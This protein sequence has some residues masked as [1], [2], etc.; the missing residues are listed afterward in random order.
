MSSQYRASSLRRASVFFVPPDALREAS[1]YS[2]SEF[3]LRT[4]HDLKS[5][6][7]AIRTSAELMQ[8]D[9]AAAESA[10]RHLGTILTGA[11]NIDVLADGLIAYSLATQIEPSSFRFAGSGALLRAA[12]ARL[13][14]EL[15]AQNAEVTYGDLPRVFGDPDRLTEVFDALLKNAVRY[16]SAAPPRIRVTAEK[17]PG[18]WLF[19]VA[20]NGAGIE[21]PW[22]ERIFRPFERLQSADK[23]GAGLGLATCRAIVERHGGKMW[24]QSTSGEG[25]TFFFTLPAAEE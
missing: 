9:G 19:A 22:L 24:A 14:R 1:E 20:D 8:R 21:A 23:T 7:R 12:L 18:G 4:C 25:S 17:G 10:E 2:L 6:L 15:Q 5:S 3:L 11:R 13:S 16:R